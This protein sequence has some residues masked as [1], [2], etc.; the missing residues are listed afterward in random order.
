MEEELITFSVE[1][2]QI[3]GESGG[4]MGSDIVLCCVLSQPLSLP[5]G[6]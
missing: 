4:L 2:V 6:V 3:F 5:P 1:Y